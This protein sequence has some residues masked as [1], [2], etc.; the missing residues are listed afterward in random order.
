MRAGKNLGQMFCWKNN[1][2]SSCQAHCNSCTSKSGKLPASGHTSKP[3]LLL[4]HFT[5]PRRSCH[6]LL[7][8]TSKAASCSGMPS[9]IS[10]SPQSCQDKTS[11]R[12]RQYCSIFL[13]FAFGGSGNRG[14]GGELDVLSLGSLCC[15]QQSL[16]SWLRDAIPPLA[17]KNSI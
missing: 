4:D 16:C 3:L 7:L 8:L 6:S 2:L 17:L 11:R 1:P 14:V 12:L 10:T 15:E 9:N 13:H 5:K